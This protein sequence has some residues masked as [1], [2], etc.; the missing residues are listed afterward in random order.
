MSKTEQNRKN[1]NRKEQKKQTDQDRIEYNAFQNRIKKIE[2][3]RKNISLFKNS[4]FEQNH[5]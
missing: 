4:N 3:N 5:F 1:K 2:Q